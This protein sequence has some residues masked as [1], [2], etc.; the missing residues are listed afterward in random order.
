M[1]SVNLGTTLR[2]AAAMTSIDAFEP[3]IAGTASVLLDRA[4]SIAKALAANPTLVPVGGLRPN[5]TGWAD[6]PSI[7]TFGIRD[8][9]N[10]GRLLTVTELQ[11]VWK[12]L[13]R[14]G[15]LLGQPVGLGTVG[16]LRLAIGARDLADGPGEDGLAR[17]F[18]ALEEVTAP[19]RC[20]AGDQS[21]P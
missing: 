12:R 17:I 10:Q 5:G 15:V 20:P 14:S 19:S 18:A 21:R 3:R 11:P 1:E 16:G 8:P 6:Q 2:W 13:A 7:F 4:G 9:L